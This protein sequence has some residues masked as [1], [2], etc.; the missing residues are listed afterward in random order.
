[1]CTEKCGD[2]YNFGYFQCD[3]GNVVDGDGCDHN[4]HI[5]THWTCSG[6]SS[7][8]P[9]HCTDFCG[10]GF[11]VPGMPA[12]YCDDG[13]TDNWDGCSN[14]CQVQLSASCGTG[15]FLNALEV[16]EEIC[17]DGLYFGWYQCDDGNTVDG[18]GCSSTCD[19]EHGYDCVDGT[20]TSASVCHEICGDGINFG[21]FACDDGNEADNDGC[22]H[23]CTLE[24]GWT[25]TT[26]T[27]T[28]ASVCTPV[29]GDGLI[30]HLEECDDSNTNN[31]DG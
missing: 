19:I 22:S 13:N 25:C 24:P 17:G 14:D 29:C 4:C 28:S 30:V 9:D 21:H 16:C 2:G 1:M 3:D 10:D 27:S 6:G 12:T 11:V 5:E 18:D 8:G 23:L 7:A 31:G 15:F 20:S 26:G